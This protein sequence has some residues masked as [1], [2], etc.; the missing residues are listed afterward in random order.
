MLHLLTSS[1]SKSFPFSS[2][3]SLSSN[4]K[5]KTAHFYLQIENPFLTLLN[6]FSR[7]NVQF[8]EAFRLTRKNSREYIV[9][10]IHTILTCFLLLH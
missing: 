9:L 3:L 1:I 7:E 6:A 2:S 10:H 4:L 8:E 5:L